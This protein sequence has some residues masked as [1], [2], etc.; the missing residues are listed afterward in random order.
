MIKNLLNNLCLKKNQKDTKRSLKVNKVFKEKKKINIQQVF[1]RKKLLKHWQKQ[2]FTQTFNKKRVI[3]VNM[4][5]TIFL[6]TLL[7]NIL[8]VVVQAAEL[9]D[10][11]NIDVNDLKNQLPDEFPKTNLTLDDAKTLVKD[12]CLKVAGADEGQKAY[13][14]IESSTLTLIE[15]VNNIVNF[16][17]IQEEINVASPNGELDSVFNKYCNKKED[18]FKCV[19]TF[20]SKLTPCLD[21]DERQNQEV[22][23]R[24]IRSLLNF[25]CHKGGDQIALFIAEKGPECL[26]AHKEDIQ[27]CINNT[28]SGYLPEEGI[29][30]VK[31]LPKFV[32]GSKQCNDM[33][34]L[35]TCIVKKL[36]TCD[37]ITPAN[38]VESM[39]RFIKNETICRSVA[40]TDKHVAGNSGHSLVLNLNLFLGLLVFGTVLTY[41]N[42]KTLV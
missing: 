13:T 39:F 25:V 22:F 6:A 15:C 26:E 9:P 29:E 20:N 17:A 8:L 37:E 2:I 16:T 23:M 27:N 7:I 40:N 36:E 34:R 4:K 12:K 31:T 21:E 24:I 14:E 41:F 5:S 32:L 35:E 28:F 18:A 11:S 19:E 30:N 10:L 1:F 33:E 42:R 3:I 38:I